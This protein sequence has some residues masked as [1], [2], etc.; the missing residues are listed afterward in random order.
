[1]KH[2]LKINADKPPVVELDSEALAAYVRFSSKKVVRTEPVTTDG[3][4]VTVDFDSANEVVGV[5][6]VGVKEFGITKLL[7][8][9]GV[10]ISKRMAEETRYVP[11]NLQ[12][13]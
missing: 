10:P 11:A 1:M 9:V 3:C 6:L 5:E 12:L 2:L 7:K 4:I 13:A 8:K